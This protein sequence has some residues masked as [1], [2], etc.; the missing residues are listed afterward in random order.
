MP[1]WTTLSLENQRRLPLPALVEN[2]ANWMKFNMT[3]GEVM[4]WLLDTDTLFDAPEITRDEQG[5]ITRRKQVGR[6]VET[7]KQKKNSEATYTYYSNGD[8]ED[9]TI[10]ERDENDEI[11]EQYTIHHYQDD[12]QPIVVRD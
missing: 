6:F 7:G 11:V 10:V 8:I 4:E 1:N 9:I 2:I 3:K 5:N 12:R